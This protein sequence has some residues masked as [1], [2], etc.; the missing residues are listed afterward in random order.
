M[1]IKRYSAFSKAV[2]LLI[3]ILFN[4]IYRIFVGGGVLP[5]CKGAVCVFY[6][7]NRLGSFRPV[8]SGE[9]SLESE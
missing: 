1:A 2:A 9:L 8:L 4:V 7:P 5:F 3:I 6:S